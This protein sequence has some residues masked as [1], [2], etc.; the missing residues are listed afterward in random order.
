M[1]RATRS[2]RLPGLS[3]QPKVQ[4][5]LFG[6]TVNKC[7]IT[8]QLIH[9]Y[10]NPAV[11]RASTLPRHEHGSPERLDVGVFVAGHVRPRAAER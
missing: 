7:T 11:N 3:T 6:T 4:T 8:V 1:C 9:S 2:S 5:V 10:S